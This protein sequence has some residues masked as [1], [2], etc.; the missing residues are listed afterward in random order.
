MRRASSLCSQC[1]RANSWWGSLHDLTIR[2]FSVVWCCRT[3]SIFYVSLT[4]CN[5]LNNCWLA[6]LSC[7]YR[8]KGQRYA[9]NHCCDQRG[10]NYRII[11]YGR[12]L[13]QVFW[14]HGGKIYDKGQS[15]Q[16]SPRFDDIEGRSVPV[17][18]KQETVKNK[19]SSKL[20]ILLLFTICLML[21]CERNYFLLRI[22]PTL[23]TNDLH[24]YGTKM[25]PQFEQYWLENILDV[26]A[27]LLLYLPNNFY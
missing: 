7:L 20:F 3:W 6:K 11:L 8:V 21:V 9:N 10:Q 1:K 12:W 26:I 25:F 16:S 27:I 13:L 5:C 17:T 19:N 22:Y 2:F 23:I 15:P 18:P 4:N 14:C 24:L